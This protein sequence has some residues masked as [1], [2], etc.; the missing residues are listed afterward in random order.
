[1]QAFWLYIRRHSGP[2][3]VVPVLI[4]IGLAFLTGKTVFISIVA[5]WFLAVM[6]IQAGTETFHAVDSKLPR[7]KRD[8]LVSFLQYG[9]YSIASASMALYLAFAFWTSYRPSWLMGLMVTGIL[10]L[11]ASGFVHK[12]RPRKNGQKN[13]EC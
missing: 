13:A 4:G 10:M 11:F 5:V 8:A 7:R 6:A 3:L 12:G 9:G 2:I 1:M